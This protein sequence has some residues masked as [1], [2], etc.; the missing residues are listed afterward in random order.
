MIRAPAPYAAAEIDATAAS[1][2]SVQ[3][4][5]GMIPWYAGG[6]GDPWNHVEAA[7]ALSAT[8][9]RPAAE[10]AYEWL[11]ATQRSDGAW[12]AAYAS[13]ETVEEPRLD[14]NVTAYVAAGVWHHYLATR[15][16]GFLE[17]MWPALDAAIDWVVG[18]QRPGGELVWA[19]DPD[20][21]PGT[22]ALLAASS[23]ACT[24]LASALRC[25]EALGLERARW[26][27]ALRRL[28]EAVAQRPWSFAA[29]SEFAM[30]WYY[31]VLSGA[32]AGPEGEARLDG[33]WRE[34]VVE[35]HGVL[36]RSDGL[37]VTTAETAECAIS[38]VR[39]GRPE[40]AAELLSWTRS[41][42]QA[43]GAY[44]TGLVGPDGVEFPVGERSTYS[45]AAVVLAADLL[46][47]ST[48]TT[49]TFAPDASQAALR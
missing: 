26:E 39:L 9:R 33:G 18:H 34:W 46:A 37:W 11:L 8:G 44:A 15:D 19:I 47:G 12:H 43:D 25:A 42:R 45:A 40:V 17:Q 6:H 13:D 49:A 3:H 36:C 7:M 41:Q 10:R 4:P 24:S 35:G 27:L 31:P 30:D 2:E 20:G 22:F 28:A 1:I 14:T 5:S 23:S 21:T 32:I 38:C 16:G 29:K 48:A